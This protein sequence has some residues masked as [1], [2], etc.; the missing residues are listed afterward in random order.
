MPPFLARQLATS[1][2]LAT[3]IARAINIPGFSVVE[4]V[5]LCTAYGTRWNQVTGASLEEIVQRQG[6][7][8]GE[9][10]TENGTPHV[11]RTLP[12]RNGIAPAEARQTCGSPSQ[13]LSQ[14]GEG[15]PA[16]DGRNGRRTRSV[17]RRVVLPR[18]ARR[19]ALF[20]AEKRQPGHAGFGIFPFGDLP[21]PQAHRVHGDGKPGRGPGGQ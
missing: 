1:P 4:I 8:L 18:R 12:P 19:R 5:E 7:A 14:A 16:G 6:Y 13:C 11:P 10:E 15:S 21:E 3:T 17:R 20:H 9:M 2:D